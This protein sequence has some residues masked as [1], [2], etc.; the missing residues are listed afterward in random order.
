MQKNIARKRN[1][2]A[3]LKPNKNFNLEYFDY[4][5]KKLKN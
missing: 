2:C 1:F 4:K 5:F 3:S